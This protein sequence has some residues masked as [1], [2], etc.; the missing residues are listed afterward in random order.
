MWRSC[1]L[2]PYDPQ[3]IH[4]VTTLPPFICHRQIERLCAI[5]LSGQGLRTFYEISIKN[6]KG[7][8][9]WAFVSLAPTLL[10]DNQS[11][12][13]FLFCDYIWGLKI[14]WGVGFPSPSLYCLI[15][16]K[17]RVSPSKPIW[18]SRILEHSTISFLD[19]FHD[20]LAYVRLPE[21]WL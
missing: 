5:F 8:T 2:F 21:S 19:C 15:F 11:I 1:W 13:A 18:V 10:S 20:T 14:Y 12:I 6:F 4:M 16:R 3:L 17:N 9:Q 7:F